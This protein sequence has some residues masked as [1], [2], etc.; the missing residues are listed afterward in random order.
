MTE[1][2]KMQYHIGNKFIFFNLNREIGEMHKSIWKREM[3]LLHN[4][5]LQFCQ[6]FVKIELIWVSISK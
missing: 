4:H 6:K 1:T 5:S 3:V 2:Q